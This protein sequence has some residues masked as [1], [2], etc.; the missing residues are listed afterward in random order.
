MTLEPPP[1]PPKPAVHLVATTLVICS[2]EFIIMMV[3]PALNLG[4]RLIDTAIDVS[5][6]LISVITINFLLLYKPLKVSLDKSREFENRF[7]DLA[8][9]GSDWFWEM[10]E[11]LR[12]TS[13]SSN[14]E[15][16]TGAKCESLI[17]KSRR[18]SPFPE[19]WKKNGGNI[20]PHLTVESLSKISNTKRLIIRVRLFGYG[21]AAIHSSMTTAISKA[22]VEQAPNARQNATPATPKTGSKTL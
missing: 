18:I 19:E 21:S 17:G 2:V 7:K 8:E 14:Y 22:T 5:V 20:S 1:S 10:D 9:V 15:K 3:L 4:S 16:A 13:V 12:F 6:I 11:N